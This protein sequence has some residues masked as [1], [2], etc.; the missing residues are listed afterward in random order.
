MKKLLLIINPNAGLQKSRKALADLIAIFTEYGY[1]STVCVTARR[2]DAVAFAQDYAGEYDLIVTSGGD[3]TL[4]ETVTGLMCGGHK[5]P[6]G[7]IPAGSTNDFAASLGLSSDLL[8][9]ARDIMEG[10]PHPLDVGKFQDRY[11]CY[12]ASFGAFTST[13]YSTPQNVKNVLGHAAYVLEGIKDLPNI[14]P[15]N[16]CLEADGQSYEGE[17]LFGAVCNSTSLGGVLK[18]APSMVDMNDGLFETLLIR[19]PGNA[20]E[21]Q[22]ILTAL[23]ARKYDNPMLTFVRAS[24]LVFQADPNMPW[25]LDGEY[26]EG[27][28][29]IT[30]ENIRSAI[31]LMVPEKKDE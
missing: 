15:Q 18:L 13:S 16:V 25:T 4:N 28:R 27:A 5:T 9:A 24:K 30:V 12:T 14:R 7:Y 19:N 10:R 2:G 3:G 1:L 20:I 31:T 22:S 29:E 21:L 23:T 11:F 26:A 8:R 6:V 17:Y